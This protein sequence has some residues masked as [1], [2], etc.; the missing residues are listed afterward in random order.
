[1]IP[2]KLTCVMLSILFW[3]NAGISADMDMRY[4]AVGFAASGL[5]TF[6]CALLK[7]LNGDN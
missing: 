6:G 5:L 7:Y 3:V 4:T 2:S 1:M